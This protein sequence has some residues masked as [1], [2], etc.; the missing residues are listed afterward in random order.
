MLAALAPSC[1]SASTSLPSSI[2]LTNLLRHFDIV[3]NVRVQIARETDTDTVH[4]YLDY[5]IWDQLRDLGLLEGEWNGC[6]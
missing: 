5:R 1:Q 4:Q 3:C 6:R 2:V